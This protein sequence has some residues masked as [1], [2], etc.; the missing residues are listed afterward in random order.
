MCRF[1]KHTP[2]CHWNAR[3]WCLTPLWGVCNTSV[4]PTPTESLLTPKDIAA[5]F[6][7]APATVYR[8]IKAGQVPSVRVGRTVRVK[9]TDLDRILN[10]DLE[11]PPAA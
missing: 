9:R 4:V 3:G 7:V 11:P 8:W 2:E 10:P 5:Q 6:G 1:V